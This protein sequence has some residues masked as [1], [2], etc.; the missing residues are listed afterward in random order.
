MSLENRIVEL[1]TE[2]EIKIDALTERLIKLEE[3]LND[4]NQNV[5]QLLTEIKTHVE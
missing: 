5:S 4:S 3:K 2:K 1:K